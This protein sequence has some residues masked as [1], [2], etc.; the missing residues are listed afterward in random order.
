MDFVDY[1]P[2]IAENITDFL[3]LDSVFPFV[4]FGLMIFVISMFFKVMRLWRV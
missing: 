1:I 3:L 2:E 4:G